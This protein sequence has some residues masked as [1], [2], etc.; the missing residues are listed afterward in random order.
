[1]DQGEAAPLNGKLER[2]NLPQMA[3]A[4]MPEDKQ[5][6]SE[7]RSAQLP[8]SEV[9]LP[10]ESLTQS[11]VPLSDIHI[12]WPSA[13]GAIGVQRARFTLFIDE[14]GRVVKMVPDGHSLQPAMEQAAEEAFHAARFLPAQKGGWPVK[15]MLRIEVSFEAI[16]AEVV[17]K[18]QIQGQRVLQ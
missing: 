11:A 12:P 3:A 17:P 6:S 8:Q 5:P 4:P 18:A 14:T 13:G 7:I 15:S 1:M 10:K 16:P 2:Q 9:F